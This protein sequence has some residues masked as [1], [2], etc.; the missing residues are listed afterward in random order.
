MADALNE[1][2]RWLVPAALAI[3][4]ALAAAAVMLYREW[5]ASQSAAVDD[6]GALVSALDAALKRPPEPPAGIAIRPLQPPQV[7][8]QDAALSQAVCTS[9]SDALVR[10]P[11]LRVVACRSTAAA[12]AAA[13]DDAALARLLAVRHVLTGSVA[14]RP[15]GRVHVR[16]ALVEAR[17]AARVWHIDE[18][19]TDG[20]LQTL[21]PRVAE[22]VARAIGSPAPVTGDRPVAPDL[23][24]VY[25]K[26]QMLA[27]QPSIDA[28]RAAVRLLDE[29]AAADPDY[30]PALLLRHGIRGWLLGNLDEAR[31]IAALNAARAENVAEGLALARRIVARDPNDPRGQWLLLADEIE[32]GQWAAG[33]DRLDAMLASSGNDA[34]LLRT[35]A[36]LHLHAGYLARAQ[37]LAVAAANIDALDAQTF[38]VLALV[39]GMQQRNAA[40]RE[41]TAIA[42]QLGHEGMGRLEMVDAWRRGDWALLE[43]TYAQWVGWG[44]KWSNDWVPQW[45]RGV[46][47]PAQREAAVALLDGHDA[48]TRQHFVSYFIEYALLGDYARSLAAIRHHARLP[49]ATWMQGLWWPE[50]APVRRD[51]Q[52]AEAMADLGFIALWEARGA[53]DLCERAA[54]GGWRCR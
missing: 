28:R 36:K 37:A 9:V 2:L 48:A 33:F 7:S 20:E 6:G 52:F 54:S 49:P 19:I 39:A 43:R 27:R 18:E 25:L 11:A 4:L 35:A 50:L 26:A 42:R 47:D 8:E 21:L 12:V 31:D 16:L 40:S 5:P 15:G 38:E 51:P 46:A 10:L 53:P 29:I 23:Y 17:T 41:W 1:R 34:R 14:A 22:A 3:L 30:E 13:L 32:R 45:V 24:A 44:G